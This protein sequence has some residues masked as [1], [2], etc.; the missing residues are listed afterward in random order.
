M[1]KSS[2]VFIF[3]LYSEPGYYKVIK[4]TPQFKILIIP[5]FIMKRIFLIHYNY[6]SSINLLSFF[7]VPMS[8]CG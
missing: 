5:P 3:L 7:S 6:P 2:V 1:T 4:P 8:L